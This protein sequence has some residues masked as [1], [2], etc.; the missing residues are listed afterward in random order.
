MDFELVQQ[1][2]APLDVVERTVVDPAFLAK[3]STLPKLGS[4][5]LLDQQ[6]QG[7]RLRQR[8]RYRFVGDLSLAVTAIVD[9]ARLTWVEDS[10]LDRSTHRTTW[11]ILPDNYPK[12][13]S[14]S[15]EIDLVAN[16]PS[17]T[18]R[19]I[20]GDLTVHIPLMRGRVEAAI[21]SGLREHSVLEADLVNRWV[22]SQP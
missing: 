9:P 4:P 5:V 20:G 15:G 12:L 11:K 3:L 13:L 8:V 22:A 16:G 18:T 7:N 17:A 1:L 19:T 6:D 14:A 21:V 2:R 10:T